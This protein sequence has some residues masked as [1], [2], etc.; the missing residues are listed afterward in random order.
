MVLKKALIW[1]INN[2]PSPNALQGC[3]NDARD[4]EATLLAKGFTCVVL[5]DSMA[6]KAN[7]LAGFQWLKSG[8]VDGD[9]IVFAGSSHGTKVADPHGDERDRF[10]EAIVCYYSDPA[11]FA[12]SLLIDD[13]IQAVLATVPSGVIVEGWSDSC[14]S[15]TISKAAQLDPMKYKSRCIPGPLTCGK[16]A[17]KF[18][19]MTP[20]MK[21]C[22]WSACTDAQTAAEGVVTISGVPTHR[23]FFSYKMC[24]AIRSFVN[25]KSR[26]EIQTLVDNAVRRVIA[27]QTPMLECS[28]ENAGKKLFT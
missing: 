26:S 20:G 22:M 23:G 17:N 3:V 14:Y 18:L 28:V 5:L 8:A 12:N 27:N 19:S 24:Q 10:D 15:G 7:I 6:T 21:E 4:Y 13:E 1:G 2:Y 16:K 25:T 9:V 11:Q